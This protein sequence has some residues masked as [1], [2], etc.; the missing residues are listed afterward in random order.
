MTANDVIK[1]IETWA[2][3]GAGWEK[4][5]TGIQVGSR[6][7]KI[8][9]I[10]LSLELN[11][12]SL[13]Q[14]IKRNSNFIFT[15]HPFI[16]TPLKKID[17]VTDTKSKLI[18][19]LIKKEITLYS[20]H[21]NLDFTS[22][23]VSYQLAKRLGLEN[24]RFL[25][26]EEGNQY[27][28][29]IYVSSGDLNKISSATFEAGGGIIGEYSNC[30]AY[31]NVTGTF[32]GNSSSNPTYGEKER[33]EKVDEIRLEVLVNKWNLKKVL[34]AVKQAHSYEEPAIDIYPLKNENVNYGYGVIGN[35]RK[36]LSENE[37]LKLVS[38]QLN[39]TS[40]KYCKGKKRKIKN[41]AVCGGSGSELVNFA[42]SSGADAFVTADLKYHTFQDAEGKILLIDA[43]HYETEIW[44]LDEVKKRLDSL[45][46]QK[47][48]SI[49]V[50]KYSG[51]TNPV[52]IFN[53]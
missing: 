44:I 35:L 46:Q 9:N 16:F 11:Q 39:T 52:K 29:V 38:G 14:A 21:T 41:I 6:N 27:K 37:F 4:D 51:S 53:N 24:L 30:S 19:T 20:A 12:S 31:S 25:Q 49:K 28:L 40:L 26:N 36:S 1:Y 13:D 42:I 33:F 47:K 48:S 3:P 2:P 43:G 23:G 18:E 15:H 34:A 8:K 5:N 17:L 45:I 22:G 7:R 32:K 50:Y 10:F